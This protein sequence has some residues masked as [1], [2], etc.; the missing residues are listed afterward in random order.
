[1]NALIR[2]EVRLLLPSFLAGLVVVKI[3]SSIGASPWGRFSS[4]RRLPSILNDVP[5]P[6]TNTRARFRSS[7]SSRRA[8]AGTAGFRRSVILFSTLVLAGSR[9]NVKSTVSMK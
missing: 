9:S 3:S 7:P 2:K 5:C 1:M 4:T 6:L 8:C